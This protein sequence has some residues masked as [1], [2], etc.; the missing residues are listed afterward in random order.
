MKKLMLLGALLFCGCES[1]N[2]LNEVS[3]PVD[4]ATRIAEAFVDILTRSD[5]NQDG[6]VRGTFEGLQLVL[7]IYAFVQTLDVDTD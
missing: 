5:L 4:E 3:I 1:F 2:D 6:Q 7:N